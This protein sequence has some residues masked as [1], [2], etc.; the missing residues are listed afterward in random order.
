MSTRPH[1]F[2]LAAGLLLVAATAQ[3]EPSQT[4][5]RDLSAPQGITSVSSLGTPD[6]LAGAAATAFFADGSS[7]RALFTVGGSGLLSS[8]AAFT[9]RFV[10]GAEAGNDS[11]R[12]GEWF[13]TNLDATHALVGFAIEGYG[14][15]AG[16]AAFDVSSFTTPAD[17]A[18]SGSG[19]DL[20]M[21]FTG[22]SFIAGSV[23]ITYSHP[24]AMPGDPAAGDLFGRVDVALAYTTATLGGGLPAGGSV[25]SSQRFGSDLDLV[26]YA[27]VVPEPA[28]SALLLAGLGALGA[29]RQRRCKG[30]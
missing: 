21:N 4:V 22:R 25:F 23:G 19:I 5:T 20:L 1:L 28:S 2:V 15:G 11:S 14:N 6:V 10:L 12:P 30:V 8:A 13:I 18:G 3:A 7:D 9:T 17:T 29:W 16:H 24:L 26:T 27:A